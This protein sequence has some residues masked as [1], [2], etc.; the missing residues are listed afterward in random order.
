MRVLVRKI[1]IL[2]ILIKKSNFGKKD[3]TVLTLVELK[4]LKKFITRHRVI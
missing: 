2:L 1:V 4:K 3:V